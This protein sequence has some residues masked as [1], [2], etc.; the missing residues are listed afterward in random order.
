MASSRDFGAPGVNDKYGTLPIDNDEGQRVKNANHKRKS[1][2]V[3]LDE[4]DVIKLPPVI[5]VN[6][7]TAPDKSIK[8]GSQ[9]TKL[10]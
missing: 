9:D 6:L 7:N 1:S 8:A 5:G 4:E 10:L 3:M 2:K